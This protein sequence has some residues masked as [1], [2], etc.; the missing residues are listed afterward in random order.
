MNPLI[1]FALRR[2]G[3]ELRRLPRSSA[4]LERAWLRGGRIPWSPGYA[5]ARE[6]FIQRVFADPE[7]MRAFECG[8]SLPPGFG[9]A[10]DER[11][12]EYPWAL[13]R[14]GTLSG[15]VLDAGSALNHAFLVEHRALP[16]KLLH[17][18]TLAPEG[19]CFWQKGI[20]YLY[21]DLRALPMRDGLYDV[22]A[23]I[24]TLEHVGC[25]NS[26]YTGLSIHRE[27]RSADFIGVMQEFRRV[28]KPG[29]NLLLTVPYGAHAFL[30]TFQQFD[31]RLLARAVEAFGP[32]ARVEQRYYRY[33][34]Q[35]WN[36]SNA[37][38]CTGCKYVARIM[39][40]GSTRP[41]QFP[42]QQDGAAAARAV[43]CVELVR[44]S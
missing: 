31:G 30:G 42:L 43:A 23:C 16:H 20:S 38:D 3:L 39:Q 12:V 19:N 4:A 13:S 41:A 26:P 35:G 15:R 32:C 34:A 8:S 25:D 28:L 11:C 14:L 17:M 2:F 9:V 40:S 24:S 5:Q 22:I 7:M 10:L 27:R 6:R 37:M 33:T 36:L 1:H 44:S 18:L 29:G 21:E